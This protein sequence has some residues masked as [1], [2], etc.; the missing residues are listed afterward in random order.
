MYKVGDKVLVEVEIT[1]VDIEDSI[2][3]YEIDFYEET[4][5]IGDKDIH[6]ASPK[7]SIDQELEME[8][9]AAEEVSEEL[10]ELKYK[11]GDK[12]QHKYKKE[13]G[14]GVIDEINLGENTYEYTDYS[15]EGEGDIYAPYG[16][17][18]PSFKYE[19][20]GDSY[21]SGWYTAESN[22]ELVRE[23]N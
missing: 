7:L 16:V 9:K 12:V 8:D 15:Y 4:Y 13:W 3:P 20:N 10:P 2:L 17:T 23:E 11:I 5:W 1:R 6:S 19:E 21:E 14:I 18:Y 22:I